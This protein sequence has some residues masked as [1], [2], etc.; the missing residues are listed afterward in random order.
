[1]ASA[2]P[3]PAPS[4]AP[5]RRG[6]NTRPRVAVVG[7]GLA[8]LTAAYLLRKEGADVW[9]V[10]KVCSGRAGGVREEKWFMQGDSET[11]RDRYPD[12]LSNPLYVTDITGYS[13]WLSRVVRRARTG[14]QAGD[15]HERRRG[16]GVEGD[17]VP[18][19]GIHGSRRIADQV[20]PAL[21]SR[22]DAGAPQDVV[23]VNIVVSHSFASIV[24]GFGLPIQ[25][26]QYP[27]T[28]RHGISERSIPFCTIN[29]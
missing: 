19:R 4:P 27:V 13:T 5:S 8:G 23:V 3:S 11:G 25:H 10:E 14:R 9:L 15:E 18:V 7:S 2:Y 24:A 28:P 20:P 29:S 17:G 6:S 21:L 22:V 26:G 12:A 1:M 16:R